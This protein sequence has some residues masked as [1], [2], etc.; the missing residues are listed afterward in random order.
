MSVKN[1]HCT[2]LI[3]IYLRNKEAQQTK[4]Y[5]TRVYMTAW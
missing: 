4:I 2:A 1:V 3:Q 5:F